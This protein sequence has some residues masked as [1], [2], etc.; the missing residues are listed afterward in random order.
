MGLVFRTKSGELS[1]FVLD[2][3]RG[4]PQI[5]QFGTGRKRLAQMNEK[6]EELSEISYS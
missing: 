3:L 2:S 4:L 1:A 5:Q 6:M